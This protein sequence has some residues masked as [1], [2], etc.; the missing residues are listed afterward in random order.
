MREGM[1]EE[2]VEQMRPE[3][4]LGFTVYSKV[5]WQVGTYLDSAV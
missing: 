2:K 3:M 1:E 4:Y 5:G